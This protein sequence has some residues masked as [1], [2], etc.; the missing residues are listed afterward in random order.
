MLAS[1]SRPSHARFLLLQISQLYGL[2]LDQIIMLN[3]R[4]PAANQSYPNQLITLPCCNGGVATHPPPPPPPPPSSGGLPAGAIAGI[5]AGA[6]ALAVGA[7]VG[8]R[9]AA[10]PG[11]PEG[12]SLPQAGQCAGS[13]MRR[14]GCRALLSDVFFSKSWLPPA[15]KTAGLTPACLVTS[16]CPPRPPLQLFCGAADGGSAPPA[17]LTTRSSSK[18]LLGL[19]WMHVSCRGLSR[20][21]L[22]SCNCTA[23]Q[24]MVSECRT[25]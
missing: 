2:P 15:E 9:Q 17:R 5:A 6:G 1:T 22:C 18:R 20:V 4:I 12:H 11:V 10:Q 8:E 19:S 24:C 7:V 16:A 23:E 25:G 13:S 14:F 21:T 3:P